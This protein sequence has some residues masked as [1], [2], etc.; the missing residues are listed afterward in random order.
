MSILEYSRCIKIDFDKP[1]LTDVSTIVPTEETIESGFSLSVSGTN[2]SYTSANLID[3]NTSTYWRASS[4]GSGQ[5]I[6]ASFSV[7]KYIS[8]MRFYFGYSSGR[9]NAYS[10]Q[11]SFDNS[12]W[13]EVLSGN[14][15]ND[16]IWQEVL[17]NE[18]IYYKYW[19]VVFNSKHSSYYTCSEIEFYSKQYVG[20]N[21]Y[22]SQYNTE[23]SGELL[24]EPYQIVKI[25]KSADNLSL[26]LWLHE[27][28]RMKHPITVTVD[29]S[30]S[31]MGLGGSSVE[32][33]IETFTPVNITPIFNPNDPEYLTMKVPSITM[34][35]KEVIYSSAQSGDEYL[36]AKVSGI[37][38]LVTKVGSLPL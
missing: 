1:I 22:G 15:V 7:L 31:L 4:T 16:S 21:V 29:F 33:F 19:R 10:I 13:T 20:W 2:S 14:F 24:T 32:P 3:G 11:G 12:S 6:M 34:Q 8:K 37:D 30:G 25:T 18:P 9:P 38:I 27:Q 26:F 17:I 36:T 28:A 35:V 23:P 5:W